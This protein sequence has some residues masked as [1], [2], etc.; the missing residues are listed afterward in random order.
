MRAQL[1][2]KEDPRCLLP[3]AELKKPFFLHTDLQPR[4]L[5]LC[6]RNIDKCKRKYLGEIIRHTML[7][8]NI[9]IILWNWSDE[10]LDWTTILE[11]HPGALKERLAQ[12]MKSRHSWLGNVSGST[13]RVCRAWN[14]LIKAGQCRSFPWGQDF[15]SRPFQVFL[16]QDSS[17]SKRPGERSSELADAWIKTFRSH[18]KT[19]KISRLLQLWENYVPA[20][21]C[22]GAR[23]TGTTAQ[24]CST[25][26]FEGAESVLTSRQKYLGIFV[27]TQ[28]PSKSRGIFE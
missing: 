21:A 19:A 20:I 18:T 12:Y 25:G 7:P 13:F 6:L 24:K 22:Q 3:K 5:A 15:R 9:I 11:I 23:V 28:I 17:P 10:I 1:K 4:S 16:V 27:Y 14:A 26:I 8:M 2:V